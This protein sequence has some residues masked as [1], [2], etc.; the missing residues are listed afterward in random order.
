MKLLIKTHNGYEYI[1]N[2]IDIYG[3]IILIFLNN[4]N[5]FCLPL[6]LSLT[7]I[8]FWFLPLLVL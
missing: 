4:Y 1:E 3:S 8:L 6:G 7:F 5:R 2:R